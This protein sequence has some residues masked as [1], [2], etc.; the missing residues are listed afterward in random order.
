MPE[1]QASRKSQWAPLPVVLRF[2]SGFG[3]FF[4]AV[5]VV[6][7]TR[8][9]LGMG[10]YLMG[11]VSVEREEW[12]RIAAPLM[13]IASIEMLVVT[14]AILRRREW[15]RHAVMLLWA[16]VGVYALLAGLI[17]Q[18]EP[19]LVLR[20]IVQALALGVLSWWYLYKK[21]ATVKYFKSLQDPPHG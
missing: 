14:F 9:I 1:S 7:I 18:V 13:V 5:T 17:W 19:S 11:G 10:P 2:A 6:L 20:A 3:F 12:L 4:T 21:P 15:S 16:T 8:A